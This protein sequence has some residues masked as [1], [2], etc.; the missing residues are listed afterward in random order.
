MRRSRKV[1]FLVFNR[2][3]RAIAHVCCVLNEFV[4]HRNAWLLTASNG[5]QPATHDNTRS[6]AMLGLC[7]AYIASPVSYLNRQSGLME[8]GKRAQG[9]KGRKFWFAV[10][11]L[12]ASHGSTMWRPLWWIDRRVFERES[13]ARCFECDPLGEWPFVGSFSLGFGSI[14]LQMMRFLRNKQGRSSISFSLFANKHS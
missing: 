1:A 7:N 14:R 8:C 5:M 12:T 9:R 4:V 11:L 6:C 3:H 2:L 10:P 13:E